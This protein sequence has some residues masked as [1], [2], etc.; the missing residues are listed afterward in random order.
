[1]LGADIRAGKYNVHLGKPKE[2][3]RN[4]GLQPKPV[5]AYEGKISLSLRTRRSPGA[6]ASF[7]HLADSGIVEEPPG[8]GGVPPGKAVALLA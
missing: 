1:M 6:L 5:Q 4:S 2:T 7:L 8:A 3:V